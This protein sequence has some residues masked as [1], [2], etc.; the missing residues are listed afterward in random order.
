MECNPVER[1]SA[2]RLKKFLDCPKSVQR[3]LL[4]D[5]AIDQADLRLALAYVSED[6][7]SHYVV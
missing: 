1:S 4:S 2:V 3:M 5:C 7:F 6:T